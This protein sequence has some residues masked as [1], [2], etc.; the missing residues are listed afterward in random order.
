MQKIYNDPTI[1]YKL[2]TFVAVRDSS[3]TVSVDMLVNPPT[4]EIDD[5]QDSTQ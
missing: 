3:D 5:P 1:P 2:T 4:E